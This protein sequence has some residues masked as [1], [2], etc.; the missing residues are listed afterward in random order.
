MG[1]SIVAAGVLAACLLATCASAANSFTANPLNATNELTSPPPAVTGTGYANFTFVGTPGAFTAV[2]Y[3]ITVNGLSGGITAAHVHQGTATTPSGPVVLW[4]YGPAV[5]N[6]NASFTGTLV[7]SVSRP[8]NLT[9]SLNAKNLTSLDDLYALFSNASAY[10]NVHTLQYP[11]GAI[12]GEVVPLS[13]AAAPAPAPGNGAA[14][15]TAGLASA[16]ALLAAV[17]GMTVASM[18][19]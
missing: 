14:A 9:Y 8:A 11:G 1:R 13:G 12:R 3:A 2:N 5:P 4:L 6:S 7:S 18:V 10:V 19:A 15:M 16:W 17:A